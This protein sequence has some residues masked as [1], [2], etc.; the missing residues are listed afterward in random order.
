[1]LNAKQE[2]TKLPPKLIPRLRTQ[3]EEKEK[4]IQGDKIKRTHSVDF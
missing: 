1:M 4:T 2:R 3:E